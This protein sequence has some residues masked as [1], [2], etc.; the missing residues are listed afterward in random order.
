MVRDTVLL[1]LIAIAI[2]GAACFAASIMDDW[3][4]DP[5]HNQVRIK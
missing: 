4:F 2:A 1:V 3:Q 5:Q